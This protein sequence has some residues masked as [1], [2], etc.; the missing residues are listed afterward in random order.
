MHAKNIIRIYAN[1]VKDDFKNMP[2]NTEFRIEN[3]L[4]EMYSQTD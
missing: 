4:Q 2:A 3:K 1:N